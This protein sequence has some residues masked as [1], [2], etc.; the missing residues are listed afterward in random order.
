VNG[1]PGS[2]IDPTGLKAEAPTFSVTVYASD[3]FYGSELWW[4]LTRMNR[5]DSTS[6]GGGTSAEPNAGAG[7]ARSDRL[8]SELDSRL[9]QLLADLPGWLLG[10]ALD[11]DECYTQVISRLS[12]IEGFDVGKFTNYL[13]M[14][15]TFYNGTQSQLAVAGNV[16]SPAAA[17]AAYGKGATVATVFRAGATNAV[18]SITAP[19]LTVFLDPQAIRGRSAGGLLSFLF[20]EALHGYGGTLGGTSFFDHDIQVALFGKD[21]PKVGAPSINI[22]KF[23]EDHCFK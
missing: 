17:V 9:S 2:Y 7:S 15:G 19:T 4:L 3:G 10:S 22:T 5:L 12:A 14:G 16:T 18:T 23:I 20:H 11:N 21:S 13:R 8:D 6:G 1:D